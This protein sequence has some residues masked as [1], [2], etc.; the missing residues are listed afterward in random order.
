MSVYG[1]QFSN[2]AWSDFA[3]LIEWPTRRMARLDP[4]KPI[5]IAEWGVGEFPESGNK[6][7]MDPQM[8]LRS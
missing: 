4:T 8:R 2:E 7:E 1:Q 5:M 3:P 6:A